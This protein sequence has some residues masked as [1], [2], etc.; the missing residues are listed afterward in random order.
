MSELL[1]KFI[2]FD[3]KMQKSELTYRMTGNYETH[4]EL[5]G[6]AKELCGQPGVDELRQRIKYVNTLC[7]QYLGDIELKKAITVS[8]KQLRK[9]RKQISRKE[10]EAR[11]KALIVA[12]NN[13]AQGIGYEDY[14]TYQAQ[15]YEIDREMLD[16]KIQKELEPLKVLA[17]N[18]SKK[19]VEKPVYESL[20]FNR[21]FEI[22]NQF[23]LAKKTLDVM[24]FN[25]DEKSV[26][27]HMEKDDKKVG[28]ASVV[29]VSIP[30]EIHVIINP[31]DGFGGFSSL[32]MHELGHAVYYNNLNTELD[33]FD[34]QPYNAMINE[35]LAIFFQ[36]AV[37]TDEWLQRHLETGDN[38]FGSRY[39]TNL[40]TQICCVRFENKIYELGENAESFDEVWR[41]IVDDTGVMLDSHW[42]NH[43]FFISAPSY[44]SAYL[45]GEF[46]AEDLRAYFNRKFNT[47]FNN[48]TYSALNS[49]I[50]NFGKKL[51]LDSLL[52]EIGF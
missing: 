26:I 4:A 34:R 39:Y 36:T 9:D 7:I 40:L 41:K 1:K 22:S 46:F 17:K 10:Y 2:E 49:L 31:V 3:K 35:G 47:I 15:I 19:T 50:F 32:L 44:F 27:I 25:I 24:G 20:F 6:V 33:F 18:A 42:T 11:L 5:D 51:D 37:Q 52:L 30:C 12:R 8:E 13:Y 14:L 21:I 29:P 16:V 23:S 43:H 28:L 45:L 48:S 38:L